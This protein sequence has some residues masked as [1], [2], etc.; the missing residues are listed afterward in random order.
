MADV[1]RHSIGY[2]AGIMYEKASP[3]VRG[4]SPPRL[5]IIYSH[6][7]NP[8]TQ[9]QL[10]A[11]SPFAQSVDATKLP[12]RERERRIF[13]LTCTSAPLFHHPSGLTDGLAWVIDKNGSRQPPPPALRSG[14]CVFG[15][16]INVA[17]G[18]EYYFG[19]G[20]IFG[21]Y[22]ATVYSY[23]YMCLIKSYPLQ[24]SPIERPVYSLL[25]NMHRMMRGSRLFSVPKSWSYMM[26][27]HINMFDNVFWP[28]AFDSLARPAKSFDCTSHRPKM[29]VL[30]DTHIRVSKAVARDRP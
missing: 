1:R 23:V 20:S 25:F 3:S 28:A 26:M 14:A 6:R 13:A 29:C 7:F 9:T 17:L 11:C 27:R 21:L 30:V 15:V 18:A 16:Q 10:L 4:T 22:M 5:R 24:H 2:V 8:I 19:M 12:Y